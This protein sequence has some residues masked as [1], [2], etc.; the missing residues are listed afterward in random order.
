MIG[1][2]APPGSTKI[3]VVV[4]G[5]PVCGTLFDSRVAVFLWCGDARNPNNQEAVNCKSCRQYLAKAK[6]ARQWPFN[7]QP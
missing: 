1:Y 3:H 2:F 4:Q 6:E 5:K 7:A